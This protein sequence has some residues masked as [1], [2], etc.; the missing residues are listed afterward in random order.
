MDINQLSRQLQYYDE[1]R[2]K[3]R[4]M[5]VQLQGRVEALTR[6]LD[7]RSRYAVGIEA[8]LSE[9]RG[10]ISRSMGWTSAVEQ[11]RAE[12]SQSINRV[13]D[14]RQKAERD[15]QRVRQLESESVMRLINETKKEVK[16]YARYA[17]EI[18]ARKLEDSRLSELIGRVQ[19][20]TLDIERRLDQPAAAIAYLEEQR[21][22][23]NR[24]ILSLEQEIP[25]VKRRIDLFPPQILLLDEAV[26]RKQTEIE[27]AAKLLESQ[28]QMLENQ[29]VSDIRR[30]RQFAEYVETIEKI[31][32]R[33]EDIATQTTGFVQMREE[34]R[35]SIVEI[36][37]FLNRMEVRINEVFELQ[38]DA[39]ERAKRIAE[40]FKDKIEKLQQEFIVA[41]DEKW[42]PRDKRISEQDERIDLIEG[43][44]SKIPTIM[45]I[46]EI[47]EVFSR[48]YA[49]AGREWLAKSGQ[50]LD[51]AKATLPAEPITMSRRQKRKQQSDK[52]REIARPETLIDDPDLLS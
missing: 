46:Y 15:T 42:H 19:V 47:F 49:E 18:E 51:R 26:R 2:R 35:R 40:T 37:E 5:I 11:L 48:H 12:F 14:T 1:E 45:P 6:E 34:V 7:A 52:A 36:P 44:F 30:E 39:E 32:Q 24:R 21:R 9:L 3:D 33:A 13:D 22:Q 28:S 20:Q 16:P 27:E 25:D 29:R 43:E 31:K 17:E 50:L 23:D 4:E 10:Q 38:R 41:Q 8:A